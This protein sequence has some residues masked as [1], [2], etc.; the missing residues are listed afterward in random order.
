MSFINCLLLSP[1]PPSLLFIA[2]PICLQGV[3][4]LCFPA[5]R[6]MHLS[7]A[8]SAQE[9]QLCWINRV[10]AETMQ[11]G[12]CESKWWKRRER[13]EDENQRMLS[14]RAFTSDLMW[15][16]WKFLTGCCSGSRIESPA[17]LCWASIMHI[18]STFV[19]YLGFDDF[20]YFQT[21]V[22]QSHQVSVKSPTIHSCCSCLI[23]LNFFISLWQGRSLLSPP[24]V[25]VHCFSCF[26]SSYS[27]L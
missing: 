4:V 18:T 5:R 3:T 2:F 14:R 10:T 9:G 24:S 17:S 21:Y 25:V 22:G 26:C 11:A 6:W 20:K 13:S 23:Y 19:W 15:V 12:W 16:C 1:P 7:Y 27:F 8:P